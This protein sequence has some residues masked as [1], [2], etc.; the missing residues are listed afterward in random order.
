MNRFLI[1]AIVFPLIALVVFLAP[2]TLGEPISFRLILQTAAIAYIAG[3]IP[4]LL[5]AAADWALRGTFARIA[6]TALAGVMIAEG[7]GFFIW[8][9]V[10]APKSLLMA[11]LVG[12]IPAGLCSL[13][14]AY[15]QRF[16]SRQ[17]G[18]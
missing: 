1:F 9:G 10:A 12:G 5:C 6:I 8:S 14:A 13:L 17:T 2:G 7:L 16:T 15:W 11:G 3:I 18:N 4:A